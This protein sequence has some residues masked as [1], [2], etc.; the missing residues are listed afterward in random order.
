MPED[1]PNLKHAS[2]HNWEEVALKADLP[3]VVCFWS[4]SCPHSEKLDLNFSTLSHKFHN[5]MRFVKVNVEEN[6]D[7]AARYGVTGTPTLL[8]LA[9]GRPYFMVMGEAPK[10]QLESEMDHILAQAKRCLSR[11]TPFVPPREG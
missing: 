2:A 1:L 6:H 11:S 7:L 3:V 10:H 4:S 9:Q 5:R 8:Y